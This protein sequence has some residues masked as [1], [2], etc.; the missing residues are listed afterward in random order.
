MIKK[1]WRERKRKGDWVR[2]F[3]CEKCHRKFIQ[4]PTKGS[5]FPEWVVETVLNLSVKG[6]EPKDIT[7]EVTRESR[8]RGQSVT[9]SSQTVLNIIRRSLNPL[10]E[11]EQLVEHVETS[12][13]WQI[14]DTPEIF[15]GK[16]KNKLIWIDKLTQDGKK[17]AWVKK[18][19]RINKKIVP[20]TNVIAIDTRYWLVG[21]VSSQ[22]TTKASLNALE[23]AKKRAKYEPLEVKCD[24]WLPHAQ[25]IKKCLPRATINSKTKEK[26]YGQF[27]FQPDNLPIFTIFIFPNLPIAG[28]ENLGAQIEIKWRFWPYL[29]SHVNTYLSLFL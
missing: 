22:R 17:L 12:R 7:E 23:V 26:S 13:E 2:R 18:P 11:F 10:L 1:G 16:G 20:V 25:A 24:G 6:L 29:Q 9:M 8:S 5:H 19:V 3:F 15:P 27:V 21:F 28:G 4:D 14:D